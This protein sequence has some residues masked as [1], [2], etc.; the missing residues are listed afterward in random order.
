MCAVFPVYLDCPLL[1]VPS[2][3]F[4]KYRKLRKPK[5]QSRETGNTAHM[6]K[7]NK[8][9]YRKLSKTKGQSTMDNPNKLETQHT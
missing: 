2:V 6:T 1:I 3:F 9:Q 4:N 5:G 8:T 7:T